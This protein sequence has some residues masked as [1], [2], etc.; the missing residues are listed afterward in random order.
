MTRWLHPGE[1]ERE[2]RDDA[3]DAIAE[4]ARHGLSRELSTLIWTQVHR[5][6]TDPA[7]G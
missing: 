7:G 1:L 5:D 3:F 4:G 2:R 6:A